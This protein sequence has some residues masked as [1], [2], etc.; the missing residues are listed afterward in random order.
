[1][2]SSSGEWVELDTTNKTLTLT[3]SEVKEAEGCYQC[4]CKEAETPFGVN[5][6]ITVAPGRT[7]YACSGKYKRC[8][9]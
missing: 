1:M 9:L 2:Y 6:S 7:L 3:A 8:S 5:F 4:K